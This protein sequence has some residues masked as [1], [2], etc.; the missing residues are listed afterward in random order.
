MDTD[1]RTKPRGAGMR[2]PG[3]TAGACPRQEEAY[4]GAQVK[5]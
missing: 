3:S 5:K 1:R 4:P 2:V